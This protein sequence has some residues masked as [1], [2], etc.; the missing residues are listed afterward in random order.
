MRAHVVLRTVCGCLSLALVCCAPAGYAPGFA[1]RS[2]GMCAFLPHDQEA[3]FVA[4]LRS[5]GGDAQPV[6]AKASALRS[7]LPNAQRFSD[8]HSA[9]CL[10][11]ATGDLSSK[12]YYYLLDTIAPIAV[13]RHVTT[14]HVEELNQAPALVTP[15]DSTV[16]DTYP[17]STRLRWDGVAGAVNYLVEVEAFFSEPKE[18][19]P[20]LGETGHI[21]AATED[22]FAFVGAAWGRWRVRALDA[23]GRAGPPST[24][25]YFQYLQ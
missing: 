11:A 23:W 21:T 10:P 16:F 9:L 19:R 2:L 4:R 17:R 5:I 24:W 12:V 3:H 15:P 20:L 6:D 1:P 14:L 22:S 18:F 13:N 25:R 7:V 8:F